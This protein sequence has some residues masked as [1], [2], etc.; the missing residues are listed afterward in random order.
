MLC[1]FNNNAG[2]S[3]ECDALRCALWLDGACSVWLIA[4]RLGRLVYNAAGVRDHIAH[5]LGRG[6]SALST[7]ADTIASK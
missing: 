7:I 2:V 1:P 3:H 6:V 4:E 5:E